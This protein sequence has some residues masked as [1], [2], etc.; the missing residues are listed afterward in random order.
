[1]ALAHRLRRP[2]DLYAA[3]AASPSAHDT[4]TLCVYGDEIDFKPWQ[5]LVEAAVYNRCHILRKWWKCI[6]PEVNDGKMLF[7]EVLG[8]CMRK[9]EALSLFRQLLVALSQRFDDKCDLQ[10]S[11]GQS[12]I[13]VW[14][15]ANSALRG[16]SREVDLQ[17][18]RYLESARQTMQPT[19]FFSIACDK[20]AIK[21][22]S[23]S[24]A[25]GV[26]DDN[27]AV[28]FPPQVTFVSGWGATLGPGQSEF[29]T[30]TA[31]AQS[32]QALGFRA[33]NSLLGV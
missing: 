7:S 25:T 26:R 20:A 19:R 32:G 10:A 30:T 8:L 4:F 24:N 13:A 9:K 1:M 28:L 2:L 29:P 5:D 3:P 31:T 33:R 12:A 21:G 15:S 22:L 14:P 23:L 16:C 11:H 17:L 18:V 6:G 27:V